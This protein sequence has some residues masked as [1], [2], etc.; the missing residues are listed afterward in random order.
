MQVLTSPGRHRNRTQLNRVLPASER[1]Q[2][3][4]NGSP[5]AADCGGG[6]RVEYDGVAWSLAYWMGV[7]HGF[8]T[9]KD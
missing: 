6:G 3:R 8:L 2:G 5:W 9:A 1:S 7:Y 4:W